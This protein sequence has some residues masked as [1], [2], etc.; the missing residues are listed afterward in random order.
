M[1]LQFDFPIDATKF[2]KINL[3]IYTNYARQLRTYNANDITPSS[4][5]E[6]LE[7]F[8]VG[9][10]LFFEIS[11]STALYA[12]E[13]NEVRTIVFQFADDG[14]VEAN[15]Q[16][17]QFFFV[18]FSL[19]NEPILTKDSFIL[20]QTQNAYQLVLRFNKTGKNS[21]NMQVDEDKVMVNGVPFSAIKAEC[22]AATATWRV[23]HGVYQI[24]I[25]LPKDYKGVAQV[26]NADLNFVGNSIG[27]QKDLS[28]P[29]G[30]KLD[31]SYAIHIYEG[32]KILDYELASQFKPVEVLSV[33]YRYTEGSGN[34]RFT[35]YFDQ[36]ITSSQY[37]H[38]CE[39][40]SWRESELGDLD[41]DLY[42]KGITDIFVNGGYKS[43]LLDSIII[44]GKTIG[45]WH[46]QNG[47]AL[48]CVQIHY[49][50]T[51]LNCV[52]IIF[53][54]A[55]HSTYDIM[56]ELVQS[57]NGV[58]IEIK[59]GFKFI[60][61]QAT[62]ETKV[63]QLE[64]GAFHLVEEETG[65]AVYFNGALVEEGETIVLAIPVS[66]KSLFVD[67]VNDYQITT[68][69]NGEYTIYT[70]TYG[71]GNSFLF[72]VKGELT[73][74]T[75]KVSKTDEGCGSA[76][77]GISALGALAA[78]AVVGFIKKGGKKNEEN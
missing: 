51:A 2:N 30:D 8:A 31:K 59:E 6:P 16:R 18:S 29:N 61:N 55:T 21:G 52:D 22:E 37:Y 7:D 28:F 33:G 34:L 10:G 57:G 36:E 24:D 23:V 66:E 48:T 20:N 11:L 45:E 1:V 14:R 73:D 43:S 3:T 12:N 50:N 68:K 77:S 26:K 63:F 72:Q 56:N 4:L 75:P 35:L 39:R 44:N 42:D 78:V 54:S 38:A 58:T 47:K 27:A 46:A 17:H 69:K 60:S 5:G 65:L 70:I 64:N 49:G 41:G 67:G 71:D 76:I 25:N 74:A 40:E 15:G 13:N 19:S 9:G 62:T 32:E 53:E